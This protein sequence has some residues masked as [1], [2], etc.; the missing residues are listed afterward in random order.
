[1]LDISSCDK[2][3]LIPRLTEIQRIGISAPAPGLIVFQTDGISGLYYYFGSEWLHL[4]EGM[5][6]IQTNTIPKWDGTKLINSAISEVNGNVGI[7]T[8]AP[9][10]ALEV[11]STNNGILVPR[12]TSQQRDAIANPPIGLHIYNL[13]RKCSEN[14][15]GTEWISSTPA[16]TVFIFTGDTTKIPDGWFLC[17]G[18]TIGRVQY[19]DL[20]NVIDT[21]WGNGNG[22]TTYNLPDFRGRFLRG[23]DGIALNDP[24]VNSRT[25]SHSGGNTGNKVGSYQVDQLK[26]H[27]HL[28]SHY[29]VSENGTTN[30]LV[31]SKYNTNGA[32]TSIGQNYNNMNY[33]GGNATRPKNV[34]V[35]YIIKY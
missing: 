8:N 5:V 26:S 29:K 1:M 16:G 4:T 24:D 35:N 11:T 17:N 27:I 23:V 10:A 31:E 12:L 19:S 9:L 14:Y 34:Y 30:W 13:S 33:S 2:G 7:G 18:K 28:F 22:S 6:N 20:F 15:T 25:A 32:N 3:V 21:A